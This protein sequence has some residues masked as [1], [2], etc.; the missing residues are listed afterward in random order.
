MPNLLFTDRDP[1]SQKFSGK[2]IDWQNQASYMKD[3]VCRCA[4]QATAQ[5]YLF[6]GLQF[7]GIVVK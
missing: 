7:Y 1:K 6:F 2:Y 5:G 3:A 4:E